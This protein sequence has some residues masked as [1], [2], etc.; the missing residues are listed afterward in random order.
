MNTT[1]KLI[2]NS[3]NL[4]IVQIDG[5][6]FPSVTLQGD[7][8]NLLFEDI[9]EIRD[10]LRAGH[11]N[12]A[13]DAALD[14]ADDLYAKIFECISYYEKALKDEGIGLPYPER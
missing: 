1:V 14:A 12:A 7:T 11:Q 5:R 9:Q 2:S 8:L 6:K 13:L 10:S 4:A 3:G